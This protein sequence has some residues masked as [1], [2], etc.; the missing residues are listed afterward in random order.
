MVAVAS[1]PRRRLGSLAPWPGFV[2]PCHPVLMHE[3]PRG[4]GWLHEIKADGYRAQL[5][6]HAGGIRLYSRTGRDWTRELAAIARAA[7]GLGRELI[8]DGEA[9]VPGRRGVADLQALRREL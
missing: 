4:D 2:E 1:P 9:V 6:I 8:M 7:A 5:H 3:A